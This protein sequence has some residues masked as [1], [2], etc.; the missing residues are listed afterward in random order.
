VL[1]VLEFVTPARA[2]EKSSPVPY[3]SLGSGGASYAGPGR[4]PS[5][6]LAGPTIR[7]GLLAPLHGQEKADGDAIVAAARLALQD[8]SERPLPGGLR[9]T[10]SVADE[11]VPPWGLLGDEII[12]LVLKEKVIAIVTCADGVTAHLSEQIGNKMGVPILTL[13]SDSTTTQINMPWIFRLGP[14]DT[15]Q[16]RAIARNIY[17]AHGFQR[18]LLVTE[19]D[20]DG[21]VGGKEF[22]EAAGRL[23]A[24]PPVSLVIDPLQPDADRMLALIKTKSPQAIVFWTQPEN[25]RKLI[26]AIQAERIHTPIYLS[27]EAAQEGSGLEFPLQNGANEKD[28]SGAD[29]YTLS[30]GEATTP[31]RENFAQRY[32]LATGVFP[33]PVAAEAY[34]AVQLIGRAVRETGPN[35]V[36]VRDQISCIQN[37]AGVSGTISFDK[38]GNNRANVSLIRVR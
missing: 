11:S 18:A 38:Q 19:G 36:R 23:G 3:A 37:G 34:D 25:A 4:E 1:M 30:S 6:D 20:H 26:Q 2:Q 28:P 16:A 33:S 32:R 13:S 5:Y 31:T 17:R 12:D 14:N 8:A 7:I 24:P 35:R 29:I 10:L 21:R 27:Q 22:I 9:L 15:L